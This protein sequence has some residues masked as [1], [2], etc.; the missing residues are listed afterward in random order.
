MSILDDL[1]LAI[2]EPPMDTSDPLGMS[3]ASSD[4]TLATF[5]GLEYLKGEEMSFT[6]EHEDDGYRMWGIEEGGF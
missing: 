5:S 2:A 4:P 3:F 1:R 6:T